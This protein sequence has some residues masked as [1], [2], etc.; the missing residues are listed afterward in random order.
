MN[1]L[2]NSISIL[3]DAPTKTLD[4]I[5]C[6][7]RDGDNEWFES[8][9]TDLTEPWDYSKRGG[10]LFRQKFSV[11][12]IRKHNNAPKALLELGCSKGLMTKLLIPFC[13]NIY[14]SD[15]SLSAIKACK[16]NCDIP[17]KQHNCNMEYFVT[18]I[19]GLPFADNSFDIVSICDGLAGWW[20]SVDQ[21][22]QAL[23]DTHRV[24]K[25][26]GIAILTDCLM[27]EVNKDEEFEAYIQVVRESSLSILEVKF[28]YD[29][30]WYKLESVLKKNRLDGVFSKLLAN[31]SFAKALNSVGGVIGK[32]VARHIVIIVQKD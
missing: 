1:P 18:G 9:Y 3:K 31:V 30:P 20:L 7:N 12:Q 16:E 13:K 19:P 10:E 29:K 15:I 23:E 8:A 27:P 5:N 21:R 32:K 25:K 2:L 14:A 11:E 28:L 24:L 6:F 4:G 17:A 22:R 26:G